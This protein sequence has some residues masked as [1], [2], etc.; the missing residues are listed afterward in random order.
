MKC[1]L[2]HV[3]AALICGFLNGIFGSGGGI[4]V[5][6]TLEKFGIKP[7]KAHATSVS[8]ILILSIFSLLFYIFKY[9]FNLEEIYI[10][11]PFGLIGAFFG[12][13]FLKNIKTD[14]LRRIF[15]I[16]IILSSLRLFFK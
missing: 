4:L 6:P 10:F 8:I 14:F 5:V 2:K 13:F 7:K 16:I 1:S 3:V 9:R 12:S 15:G 11:L